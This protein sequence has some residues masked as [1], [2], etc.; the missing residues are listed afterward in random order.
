MSKSKLSA[1]WKEEDWWAEW[2]EEEFDD[3]EEEGF[4]PRPESTGRMELRLRSPE[5]DR[6]SRDDAAAAR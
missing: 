4:E 5:G 6:K 3:L 1:L 2:P